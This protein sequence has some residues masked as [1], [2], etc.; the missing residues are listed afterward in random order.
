MIKIKVMAVLNINFG[1]DEFSPELEKASKVPG[2]VKLYPSNKSIGHYIL[3]S[4]LRGLGTLFW[5]LTMSI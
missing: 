3:F 5:L 1:F 4:T 2:A